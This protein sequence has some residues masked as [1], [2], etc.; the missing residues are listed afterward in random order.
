MQCQTP[1]CSSLL[2]HAAASGYDEQCRWRERYWLSSTL[3]QTSSEPWSVLPG[4]SMSHP[5]SLS[6]RYL[7]SVRF[8]ILFSFSIYLIHL[9]SITHIFRHGETLYPT[10]SILSALSPAILY[11]LESEMIYVASSK[12]FYSFY[13]FQHFSCSLSVQIYPTHHRPCQMLALPLQS[14]VP[15]SLRAVFLLCSSIPSVYLLLSFLKQ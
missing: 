14:S 8:W 15:H 1:R 6:L 10:L 2:H 9:V 3:M 12:C 11:L 5:I 7:N 13:F 4:K